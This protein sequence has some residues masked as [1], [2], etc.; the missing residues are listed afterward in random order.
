MEKSI[1]FIE[2]LPL[3]PVFGKVNVLPIEVKRKKDNKYIYIAIVIAVLLLILKRAK[4]ISI[5]Q[6]LM[7]LISK[8]K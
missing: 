2:S 7:G 1:K 8:S 6:M 4:N 3:K 5:L